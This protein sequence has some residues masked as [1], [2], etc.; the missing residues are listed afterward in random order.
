VCG[1]VDD[2]K[3]KEKRMGSLV[4][5]SAAL[6]GVMPPAGPTY[7]VE[8]RLVDVTPGGER[9]VLNVPVVNLPAGQSVRVQCDPNTMTE[10][11]TAEFRLVRD[12]QETCASDL[13]CPDESLHSSA[14]RIRVGHLDNGNV[15]LE[16]TLRRN[17]AERLV[18][19]GVTTQC[20]LFNIIQQVQPNKMR[21]IVLAW[22][23]TGRPITWLDIRV[24]T[25]R[26][27]T[28]ANQGVVYPFLYEPF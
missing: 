26:P 13:E 24:R 1:F 20:R 28:P 27:E 22:D 2:P 5:L 9:Q 17:E 21:R 16:V 3:R 15:N 8:V 11:E 19:R 4:V 12:D 6:L 23:E 10:G 7:Q 25:V 14:W 18:F